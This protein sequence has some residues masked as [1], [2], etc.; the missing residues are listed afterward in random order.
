MSIFSKLKE[1][2]PKDVLLITPTSVHEMAKTKWLSANLGIERLAGYLRKHGHNAETYDTNLYLALRKGPT[3]EDKFKERPWDIIGFSVQEDTLLDDIANMKLAVMNSPAS[4]IIAGG[5]TAQFDYQTLLDKSPARLIVLGEGEKP[6]LKLVE[7]ESLE[8]IPGIVFKNFNNPLSP[9]EFKDATE[10]IDYETIPYETY[11]NYYVDLYTKNGEEITPELSQVIHTVRIFTRNFCPMKCTFCSTINFLSGACGKKT[12]PMADIT[13]QDLVGLL[14]R[15][16]KAHPRVETFYFTD[17]DFCSRR[18]E[19]IEFLNIVIKE[20]LQVTFFA[21]SRIDDVDEE[22]VP[23]LKKAGFRGLHIGIENFQPEILD[24]LD[25]KVKVDLIDINLKLLND[26]GIL[27]SVTFILCSPNAKIDWVENTARRILEGIDNG[28]LSPG[29][30]VM[31]QPQLGSRLYEMHD[32]FEMHNIP[33]PETDMFI[34]RVYFVRCSDPETREFQYRFLAHWADYVAE[35]KKQEAK[36]HLTSPAQTPIKLRMILE[37]IAEIKSER[38][39]L[40]QLR[41]SNMS[42]DELKKMWET[43]QTFKYGASL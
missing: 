22:I 27:P 24:E 16:I 2:R 40:D 7:G 31:A 35:I 36:G 21:F 38:G 42:P 18:K 33:I 34:K 9:R 17:D 19:L 29:L 1:K 25:K 41:Y 30:N 12:V 10:G 4:L 5:H 39:R 15:I 14:K 23:L 26:H 28:S 6:L 43:L 37:V 3:L 32:N 11:W 8:Q 20:K 13:G